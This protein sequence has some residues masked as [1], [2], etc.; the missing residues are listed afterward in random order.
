MPMFN[1]ASAFGEMR[2]LDGR[3][4]LR[5]GLGDVSYCYGGGAGVNLWSLVAL[6]LED[7]DYVNLHTCDAVH[8]L[9]RSASIGYHW[10][11]SGGDTPAVNAGLQLGVEDA[12]MHGEPRVGLPRVHYRAV[13]LSL[14]LSF[15]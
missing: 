2:V 5:Y 12:Y 11:M 6:A 14:Q 8:G 3:L 9:G 15:N 10:S 1:R 4:R 13:T 7:D